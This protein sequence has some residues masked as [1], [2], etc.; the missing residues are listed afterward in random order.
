MANNKNTRSALATT[1]GTRR[2]LVSA[3]YHGHEGPVH[4]LITGEADGNC[5]V[6][7]TNVDGDQVVMCV[8]ANRLVIGPEVDAGFL[9][10]KAGEQ[11]FRFWMAPH[12]AEED[13]EGNQED[14]IWR[15][16]QVEGVFEGED[17][18]IM[19]KFR[20]RLAK[21]LLI[22]PSADFMAHSIAS[23]K[24]DYLLGV[25]DGC[26]NMNAVEVANLVDCTNR[27]T[28]INTANR[29]EVHTFL[30]PVGESTKVTIGQ[31]FPG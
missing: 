17:E 16:G 20:S 1:A 30:S 12:S 13:E 25:A 24:E 31:V 9:E 22:V 28:M 6:E 7:I 8:P 10:G 14:N 18:V 19:V 4:G 21:R 29:D 23:T 2:A 26:Q 3:Q 27:A 15:Q 5:T 11:R